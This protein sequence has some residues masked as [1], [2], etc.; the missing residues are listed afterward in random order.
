M[1]YAMADAARS[2]GADVV[3]VSGPVSLATPRDVRR[4][5][6]TTAAEMFD[7]THANIADVDIFIAAAAVADYRPAAPSSGKI[8]KS[9]QAM[10]VELVQNEDILASVAALP[11]APFTVGFAAETDKLREHALARLRTKRLDMIIA[12]RVG[13]GIAFDCD[14]NCVDVYWQQ[15]E[16]SFERQSKSDLAHGLMTL[17]ADRYESEESVDADASLKLISAKD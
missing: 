17:V 11:D 12:N 6:V 16:H 14:D 2:L 1:G 13:D 7:A 15:G 10:T 9:G 3:L 8:K 4:I 5:D